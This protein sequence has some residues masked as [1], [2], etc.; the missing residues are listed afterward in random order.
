[1][2]RCDHRRCAYASAV[3]SLHRSRAEPLSANGRLLLG[4]DDDDYSKGG[5]SNKG[6]KGG[7]PAKAQW[8]PKTNRLTDIHFVQVSR[9]IRRLVIL[10]S[11][12][13]TRAAPASGGHT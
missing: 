8:E 9:V 6:H 7:N 13:C 4:N 5:K 1:M 10:V 2:Q 3:P 12:R 11:T